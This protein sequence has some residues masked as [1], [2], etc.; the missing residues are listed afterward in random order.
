[1]PNQASRPH[2]IPGPFVVYRAPTV[3]TVSPK[4]A[5]VLG[6]VTGRELFSYVTGDV[7]INLAGSEWPKIA[8]G[9]VGSQF[10]LNLAQPEYVRSDQQLG[11]FGN[12]GCRL[13]NQVTSAQ[14]TVDSFDRDV[15]ALMAGRDLDDVAPQSGV[16]G[17]STLAHELTRVRPH[18]TCAILYPVPTRDDV[19]YVAVTFFPLAEQL[20]PVVVPGSRAFQEYPLMIEAVNHQSGGL[21]ETHWGETQSYSVAIYRNSVSAPAAAPTGGSYVISTGTLAAPAGWAITRSAPGAG[22][23]TYVSY[24]TIDEGVQ[25]G[26]VTPIW[27]LPTLAP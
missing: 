23:M 6:D 8:G 18:F 20:S 2:A 11:Q 27:S 9:D 5:A 1:M 14:F 22:Q 12:R 21:G 25:S 3:Q 26:T 15:L 16:Q 19:K 24:A 17:Y 13:V 4:P 10:I 7:N